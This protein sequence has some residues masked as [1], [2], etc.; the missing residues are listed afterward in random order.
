MLLVCKHLF[1]RQESRYNLSLVM[2]PGLGPKI[3]DGCLIW[4]H[5]GYFWPRKFPWENLTILESLEWV[6]TRFWVH[7]EVPRPQNCHQGKYFS[8]IGFR[9]LEKTVLFLS[10]SRYYFFIRTKW[11]SSS[12]LEVPF[13]HLLFWVLYKK[14]T[15]KKK[16]AILDFKMATI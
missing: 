4:P 6:E 10:P 5:L 14:K 9:R 1:L 8:S 16:T 15:K 3:Q 11:H 2:G 12:K 13:Y 7:L